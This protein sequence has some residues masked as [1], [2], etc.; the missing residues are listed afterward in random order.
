[1]SLWGLTLPR[2]YR[3]VLRYCVSCG[4]SV[5][6][7][8]DPSSSPW[9]RLSSSLDCTTIM[10]LWPAYHCISCH[11]SSQWWTPLLDSC[12]L[13]RGSTTSLRS[14]ASSTGWRLQCGLLSSVP[15][16]YTNAFKGLHRRTSSMNCV[17]WRTSRLV[18]DSV[19]PRL[20]HWSSAALDYP[21][22]RTEPFRL[23][24]LV[25]GTVCYLST[26][27]LHISWLYSMLS[28]SFMAQNGLSCVSV[29]L[30]NYSFTHTSCIPVAPQDSSLH[31]FLSLPLTSYSACA[32]TSA[33]L[34]TLILHVAYILTFV[35][36]LC[37]RLI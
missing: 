7:C 10:Q 6:Q 30:R 12:F 2:L 3:P 24:L 8:P 14:F 32:V 23:P 22:S 34:D 11:G 1:M 33:I 35:I 26:S 17:K 37:N 19:L 25:S 13:L 27:L 16:S 18:S 36:P 5:G 28:A 20:H 15:A 21:P 4:A 29:P 9:C 31:H